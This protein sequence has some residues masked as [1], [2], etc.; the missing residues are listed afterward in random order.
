MTRNL[1]VGAVAVAG[2]AL[3]LSSNAW[4]EEGTEAA[5][6]TEAKLVRLEGSA[7]LAGPAD[8]SFQP[9]SAGTILPMAGTVRVAQGGKAHIQLPNG[10]VLFLKE[11]SIVRLNDLSNDA[12]VELAVPYGE[13]L[14]GMKTPPAD[15][16]SFKI[17][18]P[19]ATADIRGSV[20]WG[21]VNPDL[22]ATFGS[23]TGTL[24][25]THP[26][27]AVEVGQGQSCDI[28]FKEAP[29]D[30]A[31]MMM[32]DNYAQTFAI[33]GSLEGLPEQPKEN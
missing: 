16:K 7:E 24:A 2:I 6:A 30:P 10:A 15:G 14:V 1:I 8:M 17:V 19:A 3:L 33:D 26:E 25:V 20:M 22:S 28:K 9:V 27:K 21:K 18:T 4:A 23:L 5:A 31:T 12:A 32:A 29:A 13:F 11:F